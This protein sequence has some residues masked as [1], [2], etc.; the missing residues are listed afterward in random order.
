MS[1][2]L[3]S[4]DSLGGYRLVERRGLQDMY[5][6]SISTPQAVCCA[7][8]PLHPLTCTANHMLELFVCS[9]PRLA[10]YDTAG[11]FRPVLPLS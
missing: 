10:K 1:P 3:P 11:V 5:I 8:L 2:L 4:L 7:T 9:P 6:S